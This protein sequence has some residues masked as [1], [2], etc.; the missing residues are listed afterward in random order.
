MTMPARIQLIE[1]RSSYGT[2]GDLPY[3]P[4]LAPS[5]YHLFTRMKSWRTQGFDDDAGLKASVN[6]W[7]KSQ[8][9]NLYED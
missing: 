1:P 3:S 4:D 2:S 5:D 8:A 9:V 7:L 6:E